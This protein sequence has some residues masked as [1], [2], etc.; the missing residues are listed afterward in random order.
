VA[1]LDD[2]HRFTS[3]GQVGGYV[4]LVPKQLESG[5]MK[6]VGRITRRGPSLLRGLLIEVAWTVHRYNAWARRFVARVSRGVKGRK[7]IAIVALAR[8]LLVM[9]WAMLRDGTP[10]R[11]PDERADGP[12]VKIAKDGR[13]AAGGGGL[14]PPEDTKAH[15]PVSSGVGVVAG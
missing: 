10:W 2:P 7:R 8:K 1:H 3:A 12:V 5:Q 9:L 4:G 13:C 14:S 15:L 11:D 6:R